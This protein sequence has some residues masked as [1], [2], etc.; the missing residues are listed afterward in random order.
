MEGG[1]S[2]V[3]SSRPP[4]IAFCGGD[5]PTHTAF[6]RTRCTPLRGPRRPPHS[7]SAFP[8]SSA[9]LPSLPTDVP[10]PPQPPHSTRQLSLTANAIR[11]E[12]ALALAA[13][14]DL[15]KSLVELDLSYCMFLVRTTHPLSHEDME[16]CRR[17]RAP[18]RPTLDVYLFT[19]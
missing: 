16:A 5:A 9:R 7:L 15:N 12:G 19:L 18:L 13:A 11:H 10:P 4:P 14:L 17:L 1:R 3:P 8:P 6:A 2:P